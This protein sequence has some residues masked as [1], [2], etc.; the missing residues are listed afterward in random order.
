MIMTLLTIDTRRNP[1]ATTDI[2]GI[3]PLVNSLNRIFCKE[4]GSSICLCVY[5]LNRASH[6]YE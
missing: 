1:E 6:H 2:L 3:V 4:K 5:Y